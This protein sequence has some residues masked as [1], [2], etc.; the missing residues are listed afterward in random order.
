MGHPSIR[1][2]Q[3]MS[4][5]YLTY[6]LAHPENIYP[7]TID[8]LHNRYSWRGVRPRPTLQCI[9]EDIPYRPTNVQPDMDILLAGEYKKQN[10]EHIPDYMWNN[11]PQ[12]LGIG[13]FAVRRYYG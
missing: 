9:C 3:M 8:L 11:A 13:I 2:T 7:T 10:L 4:H 12:R 5:W 1:S 6:T